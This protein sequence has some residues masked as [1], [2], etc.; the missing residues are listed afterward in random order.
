M[1][2]IRMRFSIVENVPM[3][4]DIIFKISRGSQRPYGAKS[5]KSDYLPIFV[6]LDPSLL[7]PYGGLYGNWCSEGVFLCILEARRYNFQDFLI[8]FWYLGHLNDHR[9]SK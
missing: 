3:S 2:V 7:S 1:K 6:L 8:T 5:K 9:C 4:D